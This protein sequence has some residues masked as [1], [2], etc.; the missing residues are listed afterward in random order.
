MKPL[1]GSNIIVDHITVTDIRYVVNMRNE[2]TQMNNI[3]DTVISRRNDVDVSVYVL[4]C[5]VSCVV[6]KTVYF[7]CVVWCI[8]SV[9]TMCSVV[10]FGMCVHVKCCCIVVFIVSDPFV[11]FVM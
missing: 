2:R 3:V 10:W 7:R 1:A 5:F 11:Y 8:C 9:I 6:H 4:M